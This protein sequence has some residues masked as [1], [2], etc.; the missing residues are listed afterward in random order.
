M[1][2]FLS[3]LV[4]RWFLEARNFCV[5]VMNIIYLSIYFFLLLL[6]AHVSWEEIS[7]HVI[8][9]IDHKILLSASAYLSAYYLPTAQQRSHS[10]K[11]R[12]TLFSLFF[13]YLKLI[14]TR[15]KS[16]CQHFKIFQVLNSYTFI[17]IFTM[18]PF[19]YK[20]HSPP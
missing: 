8:F 5:Y 15:G 13:Y 19:I 2:T 9:W 1:L 17:P 18:K 12:I 10:R 6:N 16:L 4:F 20:F 3:R 11:L 7:Q 14:K